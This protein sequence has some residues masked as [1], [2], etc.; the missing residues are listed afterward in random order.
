[1]GDV[2]DDA[3]RTAISVRRGVDRDR[4]FRLGRLL[5]N[6]ST[7]DMFND[8]A[9]FDGARQ[10]WTV[11]PDAPLDP[12]GAPVTAWNGSEVVVITGTDGVKAAAFDPSSFS[13]RAITAPD[14]QSAV[15][16]GSRLHLFDDGRLAFVSRMSVSYW[17]PTTHTWSPPNADSS[18]EIDWEQSETAAVVSTYASTPTSIAAIT[19]GS[20]TDC[21]SAR[22][23]TFDSTAETWTSAVWPSH[24]SYPTDIV[25][26]DAGRFLI[27]GSS[28]CDP[29][30]PPPAEQ[31]A[32][33]FDPANGTFTPVADLAA[34]DVSSRYGGIWNGD[35]AMWL[36]QNGQLLAYRPATDEWLLGESLLEASPNSGDLITDTPLIWFD[37]QIVVASPG[38]GRS[39]SQTTNSGGWACC[40]PTQESWSAG[41]PSTPVTAPV[42]ADSQPAT[43]EPVPD[44]SVGQPVTACTIPRGCDTYIIQSGDYPLGVAEKFCVTLTELLE[45]NGWPDFNA[46]P[47]P[48]VSIMIPPDK[49]RQ[50]CPDPT[51]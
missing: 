12:T 6:G 18:F 27:S 25:G 9:Y 16:G 5:A 22:I 41:P 24:A 17:D 31:S 3:D 15:T 47:A 43:S 45:A 4:N 33:I 49:G 29:T 51:S 38:W 37:N 1:M 13:W 21:S 28:L 50:T 8:G 42:A 34:T 36:L 26:I 48:D 46:F 30:S 2:P 11:L 10:S 35:S 23:R 44:P 39:D 20:P 7:T 32:T 40:F 14:A 19:I